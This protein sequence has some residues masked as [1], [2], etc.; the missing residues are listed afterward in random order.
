MSSSVAPRFPRERL[1]KL[2]RTLGSDNRHE[3]DAARVAIDNL[4]ERFDKDWKDL[5]ELLGAG[6]PL[7]VLPNIAEDIAGLGDPDPQ[8]RAAHRQ[9]LADLLARHRQTWNDLV[10]ALIGKDP[11]PW[12]GASAPRDPKRVNPIGLIIHILREY[13]ELEEYEYIASA[14][15]AL[16]TH[17]H[18]QFMV[19][20]RLALRSPTANCGKTTLLD[21]LSSLVARPAKRDNISTAALFRL[22]DRE[23]PT[24][25][26]DEA[27]NLSMELKPNGRL[28]SIINSGHRHGGTISISGRYGEEE[29]Y[30][31]FAPLALALPDAMSGLPRTLNSRCVTIS[32]KRARRELRRFE[33]Y[34]PDPA[35]DAAYQQI[36]LWRKDVERS[37]ANVRILDPDPALP[38]ELRNRQA[39]NWRVLI[40]I[41]DDLGWGVEA[42]AAAVAF[43]QAFQDADPRIQVLTDIRTTFDTPKWIDRITSKALLEALHIMDDGDGD[44]NEF[45]GIRGDQQPHKLKAGELSTMLRDFK[46]KAR[47]IWPAGKR[48]AKSK[49]AKGYLRA[50][51]EEAW[52]MYV[53]EDGTTAQSSKIKGLRVIRGGT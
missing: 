9:R 34:R 37:V 27:D 32:M 33:A 7:V 14:L 30:S 47:S 38:K 48:T 40:A 42:R 41:A 46:I 17:V 52:R 1:I 43:T 4:L 31:T 49:S 8:K 28:R 24:V 19:T 11:A 36:L 18:L 16:H 15:W 21:L 5:I 25:L 6:T 39:D 50:Q 29:L 51:F 10:D 13:V 22:I 12:L 20:P 23:H 44:W 35:L 53:D 26:L 3:A 45:R 2:V